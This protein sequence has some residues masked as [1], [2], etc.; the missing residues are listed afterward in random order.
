MYLDSPR[1]EC[2]LLGQRECQ[3]AVLELGRD[4]LG[5]DLAGWDG[6]P[7]AAVRLVAARPLAT[8]RTTLVL[9]DGL[10]RATAEADR[11]TAWA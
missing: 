4:F 3:H 5:V 6:G 1:L 11:V 7:D 8:G 9:R 2:F 10:D